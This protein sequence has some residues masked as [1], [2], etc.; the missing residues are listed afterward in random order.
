MSELFYNRVIRLNPLNDSV[1]SVNFM[2]FY[3]IFLHFTYE[4]IKKQE[5]IYSNKKETSDLHGTVSFN[6]VKMLRQK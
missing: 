1:Y 3:R 5:Y 4:A 6:P 2:L